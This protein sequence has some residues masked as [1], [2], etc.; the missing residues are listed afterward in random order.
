MIDTMPRSRLPH[1]RHER[2]RHDVW[3]WYFRKGNGPRIRLHGAYGSKQFKAEYDAALKGQPTPKGKSASGT[4]AWL[5]ARYKESA[6][7]AAFKASTRRTRDGILN[8]IVA[9]G[10]HNQ[11]ANI[12]RKHIEQALDDRAKTPHAANN[13]LIIA[14][15]LFDWAVANEHMDKNPCD[16]VAAIKADVQGFHTWSVPEVAQFRARHP[17][18]TKARLALDMLLFLGLR[19]S[20]VILAGKQHVTGEVLSMQTTKTGAWVHIPIMP[21]L[22]R[23]IDATETGDLVFL[24]TAKRTPFPSAG[25][26]GMWFK[27]RCVEAGLP[28]C[29][30]HGLRKAGATIAADDGASEQQLMAMYG[31]ENS[32]TA[33]VYTKAADRKRLARGAA[34]RIANANPPHHSQSAAKNARKKR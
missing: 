23:S 13:F 12:R 17:I 7:Y 18:G 30:A 11:F 6:R 33:K 22:R 9:N 8:S 16:G 19:R 1:L 29:S 28:H 15:Q 21:E 24:S 10:G 3:C 25:A 26:F 34:E 27:A 32:A 5:V 20:D 4:V 31:W 14:R 2:N